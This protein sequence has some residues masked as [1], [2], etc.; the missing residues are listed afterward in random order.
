MVFNR[1]HLNRSNVVAALGLGIVLGGG[2]ALA[3]SARPAQAAPQDA[4]AAAQP[5]PSD[6]V[7]RGKLLFDHTPAQ[8]P[9]YVGDKLACSDCH[10]ASGTAEYSAPMIDL[11]GLFPMFSKRAGRVITL[12]ERINECVVR[13]ENG[14]PF[15][16]GSPQMLA[17]VAYLEFLAKGQQHGQPYA[18]RGLA[19]LPQLTADPVRGK[20]IY[21][22]T[23]CAACHG[24]NGAGMPPAMPPLWGP[25]SFND[26]A[27][28]SKPAKM[29]AWVYKN[30]PQTSPGSLTPQQAYDVSAYVD[31]M[32]RPRF[33][34][35]YASF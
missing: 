23:G 27:G 31:S 14:R 32:P 21:A 3:I 12:Q 35:I 33:N 20:A 24:A 8:A 30:M 5:A 13:S 2:I 10:L 1:S 29:A 6:L 18:K 34:P 22:Q 25:D 19:T 4:A 9:Q 7:A 17:M 28:M 15:P 11:A 26:G 16:A